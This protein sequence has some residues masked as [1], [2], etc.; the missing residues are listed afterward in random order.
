MKLPRLVIRPKDSTTK[1]SSGR[2]RSVKKLWR[3]LRRRR[4]HSSEDG[5]HLR[6]IRGKR[7]NRIGRSRVCSKQHRLATAAAEILRAA[8]AR[9]A[10]FL[11][12]VFAAEFLEGVAGLPN[13]VKRFFFHIFE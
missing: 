3:D 5:I 4:G 13:F 2:I 12:P 11:H 7:T 6:A 8:V 9:L 1:D 10:G